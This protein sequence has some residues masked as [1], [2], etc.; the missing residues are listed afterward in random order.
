MVAGDDIPVGAPV[1]PQSGRDRLS[2][3]VAKHRWAVRLMRVAVGL[4]LYA[5]SALVFGAHVGVGKVMSFVVGAALGGRAGERE[6]DRGD[7]L[8]GI[9]F[10]GG[11]LPA[12]PESVPGEFAEYVRRPPDPRMDGHLGRMG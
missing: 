7:E 6:K 4:S 10:P 2:V 1:L 8:I 12:A 3:W 9:L 11:G 5:V